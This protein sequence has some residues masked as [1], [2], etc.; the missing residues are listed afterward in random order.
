M[1]LYSYHFIA[2]NSTSCLNTAGFWEFF[3]VAVISRIES[4]GVGGWEEGGVGRWGVEGRLKHPLGL[5]KQ[6]CAFS[7]WHELIQSTRE[8]QTAVRSSL[9][10]HAYKHAPGPWNAP[11]WF[12]SIDKKPSVKADLAIYCLV[13]GVSG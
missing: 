8:A 12:H 6:C 4:I 1:Q 9:V 3:S 10:P 2:A 13:L 7:K 11:S 5:K